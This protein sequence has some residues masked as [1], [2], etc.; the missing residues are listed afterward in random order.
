MFK[1]NQKV[2]CAIYGEGVVQRIRQQSGIKYP[3][4]VLCNNNDDEHVVTYTADGKYHEA[5]NV[6]LFPH[7]VEIV[8]ADTKNL[9]EELQHLRDEV[10]TLREALKTCQSKPQELKPSIDWSHVNENFQYLA[11]DSGGLHHLFAEKPDPIA[12]EWTTHALYI[13]AEHFASFTPGTC[14][15]RDSLVERPE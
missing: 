12:V 10:K 3:V 4:V 5:G 6:T 9:C 2:W 11:M 8:E 1:L 7:P 15:W 13:Y 14:D